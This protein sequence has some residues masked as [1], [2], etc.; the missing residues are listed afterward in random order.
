MRM[1]PYSAE[2]HEAGHV[3][4]DIFTKPGLGEWRTG[5][6]ASLRDSSLNARPP[7]APEGA[8]DDYHRY[9]FTLEGPLWSQRTSLSLSLDGR[10]TDGERTV[11]AALPTGTLSGLEPT[12]SDKLE[13]QARVEH[14]LTSSHTLRAE[15]QRLGHRQDGLAAS[16]ADLP[17][18]AWAQDDVDHIVRLSEMGPI[19][20]RVASETLLELRRSE[21]VFTPRSVAPA[22]QVLGAFAAGGAQVEGGRRVTGLTL[23]QHFDWGVKNH[24]LR[25]GLS[26]ESEW[27]RSDEFRNA[28]GTFTFPSL[29][30]WTTARPSAFTRRT[31]DARVE[32]TQTRASVYLQDELKLGR[33]AVLSA[34]L[35]NE[36]QTHAGGAL[37]LLPRLGLA[38]SPD[39]NTT[40]RLA[41]GLFRAW[42]ASELHAE[43][44]RLDGEHLVEQLI[45]DPAF[46]DPFAGGEPG[47]PAP[48]VLRRAPGLSLP[49]GFRTSVGVERTLGA[50][51]TRVDYSYER[52]NGLFRSENLNAPG[53]DGARPDPGFAN[54]LQVGSVGRSRK[55]SA[56]ASASLLQ[57]GSRFGFALTYVFTRARADGDGAMS[58][59]ATA[60]GL[61]AEWGPALEDV[62]HRLFGFGRASL[63]AGFSLSMMGLYETGAPYAITSGF[64]PNEDG[65][66]I[67]RP[68]GLGRNAGRGG[69]RFNVD[70]RLSWTRGFGP[71]RRPSGPRP[72]VV[73]LGNGEMPPDMP[74]GAER[75][76]QA[77]LHVQ[78]YNAANHTNARRYAGVLTSP[79]FRH[80]VEADPGRRIEL[81]ATLGF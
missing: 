21:A 50:I 45:D 78:A 17:E 24:A 74:G 14:A 2:F 48:S 15:Y 49:Q 34:G 72:R 46:P 53:S 58:V 27:W 70:A 22:V 73:R 69:A 62:S 28:S 76:F 42:Y 10:L 64:D 66:F 9:G 13:V 71:E 7:L 77:S 23:T 60:G 41:G 75:K 59:P 6:R 40:L 51:R 79:Y 47:T 37:N 65:L 8:A 16:G 4:V 44:L 32:F 29:V 33:K 36:L 1:N 54:V 19:G 81:G 38:W 61:D 26:V 30:A 43:T 55:H 57:P 63:G 56:F 39:S 12:T 25:A 5:L 80:V 3:A 20:T 68:F 67:E 35:R 18:R 31:G 11:F 52:W